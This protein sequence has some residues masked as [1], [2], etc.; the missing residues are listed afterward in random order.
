MKTRV[1]AAAYSNASIRSVEVLPGYELLDQKDVTIDGE[2]VAL[3][4]FTA[5]PVDGEPRRRFYQVS[6]VAGD[7]GYTFTGTAPVSVDRSIEDQILTILQNA[8]FEGKQEEEE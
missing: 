8:T 5:Q 2:K 4:M 6:T 3:H 1:E 7:S